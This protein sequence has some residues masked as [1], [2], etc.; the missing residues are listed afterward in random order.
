MGGLPSSLANSWG[1]SGMS[2]KEA[3]NTQWKTS[4]ARSTQYLKNVGHAIFSDSDVQDFV[5]DWTL[6]K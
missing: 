2:W 6:K 4:L 1:R 3:T 5:L